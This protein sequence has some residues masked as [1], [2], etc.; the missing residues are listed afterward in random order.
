MKD[1]FA[2]IKGVTTIINPPDSAINYS[3]LNKISVGDIIEIIGEIDLFKIIKISASYT[4]T[5]QT[6]E[7]YQVEI[8]KSDI[9]YN[10]KNTIEL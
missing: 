7:G 9:R 10:H 6:M 2:T 8:P 3:H 5:A 1:Q 4:I